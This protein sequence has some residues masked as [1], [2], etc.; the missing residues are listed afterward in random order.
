MNFS[1]AYTMIYNKSNTV[2]V[3]RVNLL[4][5]LFGSATQSY[6]T[7]CR[8][9]ANAKPVSRHCAAVES[10]LLHAM[11]DNPANAITESKARI[12]AQQIVYLLRYLWV[13]GRSEP[14]KDVGVTLSTG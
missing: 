1:P 5:F 13:I 14:G 11:A 3:P 10:T 6:I 7:K 2:G 8:V 4:T 9:R 12:L